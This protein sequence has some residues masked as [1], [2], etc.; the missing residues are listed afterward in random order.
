MSLGTLLGIPVSAQ[1]AYVALC[2]ALDRM[3]EHGRQPVC[4]THPD[5][6]SADA[7]L[8]ARRDAAEACGHCPV[9]QLCAAYADA[10][11]ERHGVWAGIDRGLLTRGNTKTPEET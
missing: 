4:T 10:A 7:R 11:E 3:A 5:D 9:L 2:A 8:R 6:W 1:P